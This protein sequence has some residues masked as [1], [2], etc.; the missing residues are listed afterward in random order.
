MH[1]TVDDT[2]N[3]ALPRSAPDNPRPE[4]HEW[5]SKVRQRQ[6][7]ALSRS[8]PGRFPSAAFPESAPSA[9]G[10]D[11]APKTSDQEPWR[12]YTDP[13][14]KLVLELE[15]FKDRSRETDRFRPGLLI[16]VIW[17][18]PMS[19]DNSDCDR[20]TKIIAKGDTGNKIYSNV[21]HFIVVE[22]NARSCICMPITTYGGRGCRKEG[23][24]VQDHAIVADRRAGP[25]E[26][27]GEPVLTKPPILVN[28][29]RER[30]RLRPESRAN[31]GDLTTVHYN[32]KVKFL[33]QVCPPSIA[34]LSAYL[35]DSRHTMQEMGSPHCQGGQSGSVQ[36]LGNYPVVREDETQGP[37]DIDKSRF[38]E[39][40]MHYHAPP[41]QGNTAKPP[42]RQESAPEDPSVVATDDG[43]LV[44]ASSEIESIFSDNDSIAS[45]FPSTSELRLSALSQLVNLFLHHAE[46]K[47]LCTLAISKVGPEKFQR[48]FRR[49]LLHHG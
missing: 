19:Q 14:Q 46:L 44:D 20:G 21:H 40:D 24:N 8:Q 26:L 39:P 32:L 35:P 3:G 34:D 5:A 37:N 6:Q 31:F 48:N 1:T 38:E 23:I 41:R 18:E 15:L 4:R 42:L 43:T 33:G 49:L 13:V 28:L 29:F 2:E 27:P 22:A 47:P 36:W 25:V 12:P 17:P 9:N 30:Y 10:R 16:S 11:V 45:S 7:R